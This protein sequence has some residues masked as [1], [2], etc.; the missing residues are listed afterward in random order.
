MRMLAPATIAPPFARYAHGVEVPPGYRLVMTSGQLGLSASDEVPESAE[1]QARLCFAACAAILAEAGMGPG[2]VV[3]LNAYVTDRAHM[4]GYMAARD[5]WL[6]EVERLPAS[7][8]VIVSG[9]T[10]P[11]F[12]VEVEVTAAAP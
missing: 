7:T 6:S 2:D 12:K 9:F 1:D 10:R 5:A 8:L 4:A 3:R 11:E